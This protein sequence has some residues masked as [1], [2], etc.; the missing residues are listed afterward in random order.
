MNKDKNQYEPLDINVEADCTGF[1]KNYN[2]I[3]KKNKIIIL[4]STKIRRKLRNYKVIRII[5][6]IIKLPYI[7]LK[8]FIETYRQVKKDG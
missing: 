7:F 4:K 8:Q 1:K 5:Y 6:R 2:L 3:F